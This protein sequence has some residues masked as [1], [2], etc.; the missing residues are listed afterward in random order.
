MVART[1]LLEAQARGPVPRTHEHAIDLAEQCEVGG[2]VTKVE[3][4][5]TRAIVVGIE[6][7]DID[8]GLHI[9]A[10]FIQPQRI[11]THQPFEVAR[12]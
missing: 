1:A 2:V 9:A 4:R 8:A 6:G 11:R 5:V 3:R 10:R 7:I 12:G